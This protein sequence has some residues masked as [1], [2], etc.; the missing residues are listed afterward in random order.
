MGMAMA[1]STTGPITA[2]PTDPGLPLLHTLWLA[3]PALPVGFS[4][5]PALH[6]PQERAQRRRRPLGGSGAD[7]VG[8]LRKAWS[9]SPASSVW[10]RRTAMRSSRG[11]NTYE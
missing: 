1:M 4:I 10:S 7:G 5:A 6:P 8:R 2:M 11:Y 3:S 9:T